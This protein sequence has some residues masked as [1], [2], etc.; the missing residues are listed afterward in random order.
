MSSSGSNEERLG[1]SLKH[2]LSGKRQEKVKPNLDVNANKKSSNNKQ[3]SMVLYQS[4]QPNQLAPHGTMHSAGA[5]MSTASRI[6]ATESVFT[7]SSKAQPFQPETTRISSRPSEKQSYIPPAKRS[8]L[9]SDAVVMETPPLSQKMTRNEF[10]QFS[11]RID[12][13]YLNPTNTFFSQGITE[14]SGNRKKAPSTIITGITTARPSEQH[15][16]PE[17]I[18]LLDDDNDIRVK[19]VFFGPFEQKSTRSSYSTLAVDSSRGVI[20][21]FDF[22]KQETIPFNAILAFQ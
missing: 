4:M 13:K 1:T 12:P 15:A 16:Q 14:N 8:K 7:S 9:N 11:A 17:V 20:I 10:Q 6:L 19:R 5:T 22:E 3:S 21:K 18:D 2:A